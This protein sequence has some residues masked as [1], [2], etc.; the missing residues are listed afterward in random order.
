MWFHGQVDG[1]VY[2][3]DDASRSFQ[4]AFIGGTT[5]AELS[6]V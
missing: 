2:P 1:P 3:R 5:R 4:L 6:P